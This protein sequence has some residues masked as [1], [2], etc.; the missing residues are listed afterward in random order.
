M[1]RRDAPHDAFVAS[2]PA[3]GGGLPLMWSAEEVAAL[4]HPWLEAAILSERAAAEAEWAGFYNDDNGTG[5]GFSLEEWLWST[6]T[7]ASRTFV[8]AAAAAAG[9]GGGGA[10]GGGS[11]DQGAQ[12][13]AAEFSMEPLVDLLN[14]A[15]FGAAELSWRAARAGGEWPDTGRA[16]DGGRGSHSS[17][18]RLSLSRS[19]Q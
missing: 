4:K 19:G 17:S 12:E 14:H 11:D 6:A 16:G 10:A 1:R 15:P 5:S 2:L 18:L 7:V 3:D 8:T 13:P 9:G